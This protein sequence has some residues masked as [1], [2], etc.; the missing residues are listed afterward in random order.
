MQETLARVMSARSRIAPDK[1]SHYASVT[2]RNLV[3]SYAERN[4]RARSRSHL[5]ADG[6]RTW[7]R[8]P[9]DVLRQEERAFVGT[10]LAQLSAGDR[11]LLVAH[12]VTA[13]TP[14]RWPP[15]A[16]PRPGRSR[17]G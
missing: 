2:A 6:A 4:D 14:S 1:L 12:E 5:L 8:P 3:A 9:T 11:D 16:V 17:P 15:S 10:A 13:R 7:S